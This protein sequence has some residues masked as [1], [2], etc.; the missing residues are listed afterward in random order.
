MLVVS[1]LK[2]LL[3]RG[4]VAVAPLALCCATACGAPRPA[5]IELVDVGT[6][7]AALEIEHDFEGDPAA[8][9]E[10]CDLEGT[11]ALRIK[12]GVSWTGGLAMQ[13]GEGVITQYARVE[14]RT[15]VEGFAVREIIQPCGVTV[16]ALARQSIGERHQFK[17]SSADFDEFSAGIPP[18]SIISRYHQGFRPDGAF[19]SDFA[20]LQ[21][22]VA[23]QNPLSD[24][25]PQA[26][27]WQELKP[28]TVQVN[29]A[30]PHMGMPASALKVANSYVRPQL[31]MIPGQ[32]RL[33]HAFFAVRN[34]ERIMAQHS[35]CNRADGTAE[36]RIVDDGRPALDLAL[37][38]CIKENGAQCTEVEINTFNYF[39]PRMTPTEGRTSVTLVRIAPGTTCQQLS[40]ETFFRRHRP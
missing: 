30:S 39:M 23:L 34:V 2:K 10:S 31:C 4:R 20:V 13:G 27:N 22:G 26:Q 29:A 17:F 3:H 6:A 25:W 5:A 37:V 11:W 35:S 9:G 16:P 8:Q 15:D 19:E 40:N 36:V 7:T 14:R 21:L 28:F 33:R 38:D 24:A 12:L 1:Q 32:G 18:A